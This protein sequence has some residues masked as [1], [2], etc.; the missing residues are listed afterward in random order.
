MS[1]T[2]IY[3]HV[4]IILDSA[5]TYRNAALLCQLECECLHK[6]VNMAV[7]FVK[8]NENTYAKGRQAPKISILQISSYQGFTSKQTLILVSP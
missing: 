3:F 5:K 7:F 8:N 4:Y 6:T 2:I 1:R